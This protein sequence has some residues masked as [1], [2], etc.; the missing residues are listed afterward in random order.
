MPRPEILFCLT[1]LIAVAVYPLRHPGIDDWRG[2]WSYTSSNFTDLAKFKDTMAIRASRNKVPS[3]QSTTHLFHTSMCCR[4]H[5]SSLT[6]DCT[7]LTVVML[8][9]VAYLFL[10]VATPHIPSTRRIT[11]GAKVP[12][13]LPTKK[14]HAAKAR[15]MIPTMNRSF[16]IYR[17]L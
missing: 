3:C 15:Q 1:T 13:V 11:A 10:A 14:I 9:A 4:T 16:L 2:R 5:G 7:K 6:F 17:Y 8:S 12:P